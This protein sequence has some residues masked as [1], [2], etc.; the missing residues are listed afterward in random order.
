V[1]HLE[2]SGSPQLEWMQGTQADGRR[3]EE[4][5]PEESGHRAS[6]TFV[7]QAIR[8]WLE[9]DPAAQSGWLGAPGQADRPR[10]RVIH[11]D[12]ARS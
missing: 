9:S 10:D 8:S 1:I 2:A 3:G 4:L 12:P 11:R 6:P 5:R 7:V